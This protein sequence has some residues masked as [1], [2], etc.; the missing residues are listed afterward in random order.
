MKL[1]VCL[2]LLG[3]AAFAAKAP[4][5]ATSKPQGKPVY[6]IEMET[7]IDGIK[8]SSA[9]NVEEGRAGSVS[10]VTENL[11]GTFQEVTVNK[12]VLDGKPALHMEFVVGEVDRFGNKAIISTPKIIANV[13]EKSTIILGSAANGKKLIF[14]ALAKSAKK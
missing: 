2:M 13:G 4:I 9:I 6:Y 5:K 7:S 10:S 11:G 14:S 8:R 12:T 3:S 1:F